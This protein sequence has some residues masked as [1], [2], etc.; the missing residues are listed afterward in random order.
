MTSCRVLASSLRRFFSAAG[1]PP[2]AISPASFIACLRA[3]SA[4][5]SPYRPMVMRFSLPLMRFWKMKDLAPVGVTR[6]PKPAS[7]SSQWI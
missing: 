6:T 3:W 1:S 7:F 4:V 5:S 2:V